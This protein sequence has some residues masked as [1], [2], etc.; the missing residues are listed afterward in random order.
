MTVSVISLKN[1][2]VINVTRKSPWSHG[3]ITVG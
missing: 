3:S 1:L 2:P